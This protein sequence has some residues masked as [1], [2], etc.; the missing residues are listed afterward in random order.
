MVGIMNHPWML[1]HAENDFNSPYEQVD[2]EI[3]QQVVKMGFIEKVIKSNLIM[4]NYKPEIA[5]YYILLNQK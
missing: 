5:V 2:E 4:S 1:K 3:V